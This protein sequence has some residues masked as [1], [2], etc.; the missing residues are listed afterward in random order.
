MGG[1]NDYAA[2]LVALNVIFQVMFY[3]SMTCSLEIVPV[4]ECDGKIS[5]EQ[6]MGCLRS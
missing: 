1:D 5:K 3:V 2:G 4:E 6:V